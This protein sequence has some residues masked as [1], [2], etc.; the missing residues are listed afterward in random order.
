L[1]CRGADAD[2]LLGRVGDAEQRAVRRERQTFDVREFEAAADQ[3]A[4]VR[5]VVDPEQLVERTDEADRLRPRERGQ[6]Q[7]SDG[8]EPHAARHRGL[9]L[10]MV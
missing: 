2:E 9:V 4:L 3:R 1:P 5:A 7:K 6:A 8:G 10:G